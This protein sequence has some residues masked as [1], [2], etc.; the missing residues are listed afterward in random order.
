MHGGQVGAELWTQHAQERLF[1]SFVHSDVAS[2]LHSDGGDLAADEAGA[3]QI[4]LVTAIYMRAK[5]FGVR[6]LPEV[7]RIGELRQAP[8]RGAGRD[9]QSIPGDRLPALDRG[10]V[11]YHPE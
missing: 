4:E 2:L 1:Q 6:E 11:P 10:L 3:D 8:G 7:H 9:A 5:R